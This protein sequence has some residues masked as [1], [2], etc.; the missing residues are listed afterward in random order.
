MAKNL[1]KNRFVQVP[2]TL[3]TKVFKRE[4]RTFGS[5]KCRIPPEFVRTVNADEIRIEVFRIEPNSP[6]PPAAEPSNA[7]AKKLVVDIV[8]CKMNKFEFVDEFCL[9]RIVRDVAVMCPALECF[10]LVWQFDVSHP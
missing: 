5:E 2:W 7:R 1:Q 6:D 4:H 10:E 9:G 8:N 3:D